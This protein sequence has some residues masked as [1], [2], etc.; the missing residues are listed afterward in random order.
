MSKAPGAIYEG[1]VIHTRSRPRRHRL[2][3]RVFAILLDIDRLAETD[4]RLKLFG[5]NRFRLMS[6][7]DRDHGPPEGHQD[8]RGWVDRMVAR[9]GQPVPDRVELLCYPRLFGYVFNPL[10]V[11]FCYDGSG[12]LTATVQEVHNTFGE[13]HAYVLPADTKGDGV[14]VRQTADKRFFVS[15]FLAVEGRYRFAIRPPG[16]D[17]A[18]VIKHADADGPILN[19][20]FTGKFR[21]LTDR[22]ITRAVLRHPFMTHKIFAGIHWE[23]LKL[24]L[25]GVPY[26]GRPKSKKRD[27]GFQ[28]G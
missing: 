1:R 27:T 16:D 26:V 2:S 7:R 18:V 10:S 5:H 6:F 19:A 23:A 20:A 12:A 11:Y 13:R 25:K 22:Q 8:L 14:L 28:Q 17:I 3:Y 21:P 24:W 4:R 9:I 15:P